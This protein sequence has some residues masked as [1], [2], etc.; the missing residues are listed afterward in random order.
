MNTSDNNII[1]EIPIEIKAS[2]WLNGLASNLKNLIIGI[3][4][5]KIENIDKMDI[6]PH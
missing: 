1:P 3:N 6:L 2:S 5:Y 4:F